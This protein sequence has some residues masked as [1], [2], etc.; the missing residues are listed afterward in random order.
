LRP[1][2]PTD[3]QFEFAAQF[4]ASVNVVWDF[5]TSPR[6]RLLW[7]TDYTHI[8]ETNPGGR[9]GPGTT[10]HCVHGRGAITEEILD[11]HPFHYYTDRVVLPMVGPWIQTH[12]FQASGT[13][14][15]S[16]ESGSSGLRGRQR[17]FFQLIRRSLGKGMRA[18]ADRLRQIL[19]EQMP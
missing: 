17:L 6:E 5:S 8:D 11:W 15:P 13:M 7:Q 2:L 3:A 12:E 19:Q 18:N 1:V 10:S 9:R 14:P 16:C 4:P